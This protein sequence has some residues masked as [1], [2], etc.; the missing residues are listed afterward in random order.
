VISK[1]LNHAEGGVTGVYERH[2]YDDEKRRALDA[3]AARLTGIIEGT[4]T[5]NVVSLAM[6]RG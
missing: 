2:R 1:I 5:G 6:A 4:E 3:W